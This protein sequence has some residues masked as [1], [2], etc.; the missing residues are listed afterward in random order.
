MG[1]GRGAR[2]RTYKGQSVS[3]EPEHQSQFVLS[4]GFYRQTRLTTFAPFVFFS[5]RKCVKNGNRLV[6]GISVALQN[7]H[8]SSRKRGETGNGEIIEPASRAYATRRCPF[9]NRIFTR[10]NVGERETDRS[11]ESSLSFT[12]RSTRKKHEPT[13]KMLGHREKH[14]KNQ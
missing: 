1:H 5:Q 7:T 9:R 14:S 13:R 4:L 2:P 11:R 12:L 8:F 10:E 6:A 3:G